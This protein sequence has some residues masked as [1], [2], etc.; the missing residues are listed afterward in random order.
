MQFF[1]LTLDFLILLLPA[2]LLCA[3]LTEKPPFFSFQKPERMRYVM[4]LDHSSDILLEQDITILSVLGHQNI[5]KRTQWKASVA[6]KITTCCLFLITEGEYKTCI[7]Q[8]EFHI[9]QGDLLY[10]PQNSNYYPR[11]VSVP[12]AWQGIYFLLLD[13]NKFFSQPHIYQIKLLEKFI[14]LFQAMEHEW[15]EKPLGY[16]MKSKMILYDIFRNLMAEQLI[17]TEHFAAY[18]TLRDAINFMNQNCM[19]NNININYL[20]ELC[21]ITPAHFIRL[22]QKIFSITPKQYI[23]N[24][25]MNHAADLLQ[26]YSYPISEISEMLGYSSPAY[27]S[28]A[29]KN[30]KGV[31]PMEYRMKH[32]ITI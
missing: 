14:S 11:S 2:F 12:F 16:Q 27:F 7:N 23:I 9:R 13:N 8:T 21:N 15:Q 26:Y 31:G 19:K 6:K 30:S 18:Y 5:R 4:T 17:A 32:N 28:A 25:K 22:F 10:L 1:H 24:L 3:I 20:A 29:F